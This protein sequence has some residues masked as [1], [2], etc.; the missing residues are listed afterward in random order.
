MPEARARHASP[1]SS[2][3][4]YQLSGPS[5][6]STTADPVS[7]DAPVRVSRTRPT[8]VTVADDAQFGNAPSSYADTLS[9][10]RGN[11]SAVIM[12]ITGTTARDP[13]ADPGLQPPRRRVGPPDLEAA[14]SGSLLA[15]LDELIPRAGKLPDLLVHRRRYL[16]EPDTK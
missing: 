2:N 11:W 12:D 8:I 15:S 9:L 16:S 13:E 14:A 5:E 1:R 10:P 3:P 4:G 6:F 7:L